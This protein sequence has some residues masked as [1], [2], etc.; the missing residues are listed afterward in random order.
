MHIL[1]VLFLFG[2]YAPSLLEIIQYCYLPQPNLGY[3]IPLYLI[4]FNYSLQ[5]RMT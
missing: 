4:R 2:V 5:G 1:F 3:N